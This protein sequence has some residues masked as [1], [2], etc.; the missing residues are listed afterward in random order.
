MQR[1]ACPAGSLLVKKSAFGFIDLFVRAF[2]GIV[3]PHG[4]VCYGTHA[5]FGLDIPLAR[6]EVAERI[7]IWALIFELSVYTLQSRMM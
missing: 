4:F 6:L 5:S 7:M 3:G 1:S 2:V